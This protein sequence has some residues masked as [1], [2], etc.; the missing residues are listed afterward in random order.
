MAAV[1]DIRILQAMAGASKGGAEAFFERLAGA[2]ER[3]GLDQAVV[4]R[5]D[6]A[7]AARLQEAGVP[8]MELAFG[9]RLDMTTKANFRV[10]IRTFKPHLVLT[11][12]SRATRMCPK[13]EF[14]HVARL[15][16]YYDL[17]YYRHCD[18]LIGNT[19]DIVDYLVGEGW[20]RERAHYVPNFVDD[21]ENETPEPRDAHDTPADATLIFAMG[22]LHKNKAFD[23]LIEALQDVP[24]GVLW[25]AGEG[26]LRD[27]LE[28]TAR[29]C[30]VLDRVRFL[31]WR[32]DV[33]PLLAA[34]DI[35]AVPSRHEPLGNVVIEGW[36]AQRP[37]V[38]AASQGPTQL[39]RD[40]ETGLL[41]AVDD[42]EAFAAAL[43]KV[44]GDKALGA[45]LVE[46]GRADFEANFTEQVVVQQY[47]EFFEM[48]TAKGKVN[49]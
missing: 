2:F 21:F 7:R 12:M 10:L 8:P 46:A 42:S 45:R 6:Q 48:V 15:G 41:V 35:L 33:G 30:G 13:G 34:A 16:G 39:I 22:R 27:V 29:Q 11:W 5:R 26:P 36:S 18:H 28:E 1:G 20:P 23:V 4:I 14:V 40:G 17:K 37:V 38:A 19:R 43:N 3:H 32:T 9:G 47:V 44:I 25:L 24:G 49:A 31:G